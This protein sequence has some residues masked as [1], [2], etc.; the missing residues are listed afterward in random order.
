M[1]K[2]KYQKLI[3]S[4]FLSLIVLIIASIMSS[5]NA[6]SIFSLIVWLTGHIFCTFIEKENRIEGRILF[7]FVFSALSIFALIHYMDT[8]VDYN[9]F[10]VGWRDEYKFWMMSEEV[11]NRSSLTEVFKESF[12]NWKYG[13]YPGYILYIGILSYYANILFDGNHLFL[14]FMGTVFWGSMTSIVMYRLFLLYFNKPIAYKNVLFFSLFTVVFA[15]SFMLLRDTIIV[16]FY[17]LAFYIVLK[18]FSLKGLFQ[19]LFISF[20]VWQIRYQHGLFIGLYILYYLYLRFERDKIIIIN[21][22]IIVFSLSII[23]FGAYLE[24]SFE[25]LERYDTIGQEYV[26]ER[27]D[28]M[29]KILYSFPSPL[30]EVGFFAASQFWHYRPWNKFLY[31]PDNVYGR[32]INFLPVLFGF[33]WFII[34]MAQLKWIL[35]QKKIN[36]IPIE[37]KHLFILSL[38]FLFIVVQGASDTRRIMVVYPI[39]FLNFSLLKNRAVT[40]RSW[41]KT[42]NE[43]IVLYFLLFGVYMT[44]ITFLN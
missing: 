14:Q 16:F 34:M 42:R 21:I 40:K 31:S 2:N 26:M 44:L 28:A 7:N 33:L 35:F 36:R 9:E 43:Y 11:G 15:Y 24:S 13:G 1:N 17:T 12:S 39:L 8:V 41:N 22:A 5:S 3:G 23:A 10:A 18:K 6:A 19:L 27:D 30:K 4:S 32:I 25:S 20:L 37:I 38:I 29:G